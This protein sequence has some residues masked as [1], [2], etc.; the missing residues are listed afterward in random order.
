MYSVV[1]ETKIAWLTE[2]QGDPLEKTM[3]T[4]LRNEIF[5]TLVW[6]VITYDIQLPN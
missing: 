1:I 3:R 5:Y 6:V 4:F 2:M